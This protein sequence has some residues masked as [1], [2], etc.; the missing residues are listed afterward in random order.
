MIRPFG[1]K[2]IM[3][4]LTTLFIILISVGFAFSQNTLTENLSK[5]SHFLKLENGKLLGEGMGFLLTE[6]RNSQF[7]LIGESHGISEL[8]LFTSVLFEQINP[9]GY[10]YLAIET[11][12]ITA[13]RI[14]NIAKEKDGFAKFNYK[15]PLGLPFFSFREEANLIETALKLANSRTQ[16]LWGIDQ[17]FAASP[18]F[19]FERLY[20][21]SSNDKARAIVKPYYDRTKSEF[22]LIVEK[23]NPGLAFLSSATTEDFDKLDSAFVGSK[24]KEAFEILS[25]LRR[26]WE[27]YQKIF[28]GR[29]YE[30][31]QQRA[32]L[33][34]E[35]FMNYYEQAAKKEKMPKVLFKFGAN[36]MTRGRNS[37]NV[38]DIGNF[39]SELANS[40]GLKSFH[41][42]VVATS[43]TQN[44]YLPFLANDA[45]KQKPID[46]NKD[47]FMGISHLLEIGDK[48]EWT[49]VDLRPLRPLI[50]SGRIKDLP[51]GFKDLVFS[52]DAVL[53][54]PNVK[55]STHFDWN[56]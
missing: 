47:S 21:I 40:N 42:L 10:N 36:H 33:M 13:R 39:A 35:H 11:G 2:K 53:L 18:Q 26:S 20:E 43:G 46:A 48:G 22:Q 1:Q 37:I 30:S 38:F 14:E 49:I 45:D 55:A 25:E 27:I 12:P 6:A 23:R 9:H 32:L 41:L 19:H 4:I 7:F 24:N 3:K 16:T 44:S 54:I 52:Y 29:G 15:Y 28:T 34:K 31:N 8:P 5:N 50:H 51:D 17:E 56:M